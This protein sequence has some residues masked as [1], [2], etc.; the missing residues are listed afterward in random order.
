MNDFDAPVSRDVP[1]GIAIVMSRRR[2][3]GRL[4][5]RGH[6]LVLRTRPGVDTLVL[7]F[8]VE[9]RLFACRINSSVQQCT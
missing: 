6:G 3:C 1:P 7:G 2:V 8:E 9:L 4:G 5:H